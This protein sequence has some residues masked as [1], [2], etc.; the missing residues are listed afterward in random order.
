MSRAFIS[1]VR[2]TR[3]VA[4]VAAAALLWISH[5][6][7]GL[8]VVFPVLGAIRASNLVSGPHG[9]AVLFQPGGLIIAE[10]LRV[11]AGAIQVA[12]R[13]AL[14]SWLIAAMVG[15]L[16]LACALDL[17]WI[18]ESTLAQRAARAMRLFPKFLGLGGI[19]LLSQGAL[20]LAGSLLS[21]LVG[22]AT[23]S[24]PEPV[25]DLAP[26]A[27]FA[28]AVLACGAVGCVLD[29]ARAALV[30]VDY[31][32][33][34]AMQHAVLRLRQRPW[35]LLLGGYVSAAAAAFGYAA[36]AWF[37]TAQVE[38]SG[39]SKLGLALAFGVH[40]L[41]VLFAIAFRV[42]WLSQSLE[43]SAADS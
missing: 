2:W 26:L 27:T 21:A 5:T 23:K 8:L 16:P 15:L 37:M 42:R 6:V 11:G 22:A 28:L 24:A 7:L 17:I 29:V 36:A 39:P 25:K 41:A 4:S 30:Q 3:P 1:P 18:R 34:E 10:L 40:Q 35:E 38:L 19:A 13:T 33:S 14:V 32:T 9:D 43:L 20:L 31:V 12:T